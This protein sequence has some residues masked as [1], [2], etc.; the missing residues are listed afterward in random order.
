MR[1]T[2]VTEIQAKQYTKTNVT[3]LGSFGIYRRP[4]D[5]IK[6]G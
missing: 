3:P 6:C 5:T 1:N 2:I 4:K